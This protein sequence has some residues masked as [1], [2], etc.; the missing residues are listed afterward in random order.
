MYIS[1]E[2]D[3][4]DL[5][6]YTLYN[7]HFIFSFIFVFKLFQTNRKATQS[8]HILPH[9]FKQ[10]CIFRR[11]IIGVKREENGTN[12]SAPDQLP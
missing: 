6:F 2:G 9:V 10:A 1:V 5:Q 11:D 4:G 8:K 7:T 3:E 12:W